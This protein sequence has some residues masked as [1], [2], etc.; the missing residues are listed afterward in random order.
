MLRL[1]IQLLR[2][3]SAFLRPPPSVVSI[4]TASALSP[5][6]GLLVGLWWGGV[7][8]LGVVLLRIGIRLLEK[9]LS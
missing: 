9:P 6:G 3:P 8:W 7:L 4:S 2:W 1:G 5:A